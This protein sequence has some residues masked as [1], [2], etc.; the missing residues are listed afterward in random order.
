MASPT[1]Q[2]A[3]RPTIRAVSDNTALI[4][5]PIP[6][7]R[8]TNDRTPTI[9][10]RLAAPL[11]RGETLRLYNGK[12]LLGTAKV[13]NR[14]RT[15]SFTAIL[16]SSSGNSF[17]IRARVRNAAGKLGIHLPRA[18]SFWIPLHRAS[19]SVTASAALPPV[20]CHSRLPS[21][22]PSVASRQMT[23]L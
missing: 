3:R 22:N 2:H 14:R 18:P 4:S 21:Q 1:P 19:P 13:N 6:N 11:G 20:V 5:G 7:R 12:R 10:G 9:T 23:S 16:P 15:W 17:T 8:P